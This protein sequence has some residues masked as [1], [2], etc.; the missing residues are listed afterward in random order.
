MSVA[1]DRARRMKILSAPRMAYESLAQ[2]PR[3]RSKRNRARLMALACGAIIAIFVLVNVFAIVRARRSQARTREIIENMLASVAMVSRMADDVDDERLLIDEHIFEK[4][5]SNMAILEKRIDW[6]LADYMAAARVYD[7]ITTLPQE[8]ETWVQ[9]Q[10]EV[11]S[12]QE[13]IRH[14]LSLSR[15][16]ADDEAQAEMAALSD[17]FEAIDRDTSTLVAINEAGARNS[18]AVI[19][20]HQRSFLHLPG[21]SPLSGSP[22]H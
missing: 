7:P 5:S 17:R 1:E 6:V 8:H 18:V 19:G 16:N 14:A 9:V 11:A 15:A 22:L 12:I 2:G 4:R 3:F 13:P 21:R 20:A 10:R